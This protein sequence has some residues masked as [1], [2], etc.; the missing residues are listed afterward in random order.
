MTKYE[1]NADCKHKFHENQCVL[2]GRDIRNVQNPRVKTFKSGFNYLD[3]F[4]LDENGKQVVCDRITVWC[5]ECAEI[6]RDIRRNKR[7]ES[8]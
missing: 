7:D 1:M 6:R 3:Y 4:K 8:K 2:C 5:D